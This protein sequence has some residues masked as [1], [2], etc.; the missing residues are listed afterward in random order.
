[1]KNLKFQELQKSLKIKNT[2]LL[3]QALAHRSYLNESQEF[4]TS[5][6]RLEFLG[7]AVLELVVSEFLYKK[8]AQK[9][10]GQLTRLRSKIV[11]TKTLS[12]LSNQLNLGK[13]LMLSK[14]EEAS[15]G[16]EN[17]TLLANTFEAVI[18]ALYLDQGKGSVRTVLKEI[19]FDR[20]DQVLEQSSPD[21]FK[22]QFQEIIQARE[23]PT[24]VYKLIK[25]FGP[26][27]D[28]VFKV[29]VLVNDKTIATGTGPSKQKAEQEAARIALEKIK[30]GD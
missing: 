3:K 22:S 5:N 20:L 11:C 21:D 23:Q 16:R 24:P 17:P 14:G 15:G 18:G 7:D 19:L 9:N 28:K 25:T 12:L 13:L 30:K 29:A 6:E 10:E 4:K 1:M 2:R 26:D 8:Y 27:H